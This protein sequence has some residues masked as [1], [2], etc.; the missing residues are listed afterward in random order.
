MKQN[1]NVL[2]IELGSTR[3]K[4]VILNRENEPIATGAYDWENKLENGVW[5]YSME[6]VRTGICTCYANLKRDYFAKFGEKLTTFG[7]IGISG[8]M[9]GYL[10]FDNEK[11]LLTPFRTWRNTITGEA[12]AKLSKLLDFNMPQRWSI[13]HLY[14]CILNGEEHL[15][16]LGYLT[17]LS[18]YLHWLLTEERVVGLGEASGMFPVDSN[19]LDYDEERVKKVD[20]LIAEAGYAWRFRDIMPK[21]VPAGEYAGILT[22]QGA[23][24]LDPEGDLTSGIRLAPPEGDAGTGMIATNSVRLRTGNVSAGTSAFAM[25]VVDTVPKPQVGIDMVTTPAG[26]PVAMAHANTCTTDINAWVNLFDEFA[27][28]CGKELT[29]NELFTM[30]FEKSTEGDA[31]AGGLMAFN[32][33]SGEDTVALTE[34]RPLF[35]REANASFTLANFMRAHLMSSLATLKIGLDMLSAE[36]ALKVDRITGHGGFFKTPTVGQKIMSAAFGA[37]VTVT[38]T[39][40]EGGPYGMA[41]LAAYMIRRKDGEVLEDFLDGVFASA[42][43]VTITATREEIAG[44]TAYTEKYKKALAVEREATVSF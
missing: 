22:E 8:M 21:A 17:T 6:D 1:E 43:S 12:A 42:K 11:N 4:A 24:F 29:K 7:G 40:G 36:G 39:A 16:R 30:L 28:L 15:C 41:L 44:F 31:D 38:E 18:G 10:V 2:G 32:C 37:P 33:F 19:T 14:Q 23:R 9:H 34:G 5:T 25:V 3:I 35:M 20:A 27:K 26:L 13:S